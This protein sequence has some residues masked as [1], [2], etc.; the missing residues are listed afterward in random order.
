LTKDTAA[1]LKEQIAD[2]YESWPHVVLSPYRICPLGAHIDHQGGPVLG[3]TIDAGTVLAFAPI[4]GPEVR[5]SS[6]NYPGSVAFSL[7]DIGPPQPGDWGN[8]ARGA[9]FVLQNLYHIEFG[10]EGTVWGSLPSAGLSSSASVGLAYLMAF[11]SVNELDLTPWDFVELGRRIENQYL[12]VGS[13]IL[14]QATIVHGAPGTL[15]YVDTLQKTA[16]VIHDSPQAS[17]WHFLVAYSGFSR[18]LLATNFGDQVQSCCQAAEKLGR[19]GGVPGARILSDIPLAVFEAHKGCLSSQLRLQ[20]DHF[21]GEVARVHAGR[22][23]WIT[24]DAI[25]FGQLMKESCSSSIN[26]YGSGSEPIRQLQA[27]VSDAPGVYGS[28]FSGGAYGGC[29]VGLVDAAA[30]SEAADWIISRFLA[31]YPQITGRAYCFIAGA[32][33][34]LRKV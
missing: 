27:I 13:G 19:A 28:R 30:V 8:Y 18:D 32:Q 10:I 4:S 24:G 2:R 21:F 11:A 23:A 5:L 7:K 22:K 12:S 3:R 6:A 9:A 31:S 34:G 33:G 1:Q 15:V 26:L 25:R 16:E 20:A 14:D 29:V 17:S